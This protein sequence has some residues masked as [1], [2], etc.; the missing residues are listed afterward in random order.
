MVIEQSLMKSMK[1]EGGVSRGRSTQESVLSK[2]VYGMYVMNTIC[3]DVEKFCNISLDT[4]DQHV[5]TKDSRIKKDNDGVNKIIEWLTIH[6]PFSQTN[7]I[8]SL[9]NSIIGNDEINCYDAYEIGKH[10]MNKMVGLKFDHFKFKRA[11]RVL[12][13]LSVK[14]SIKVHDHSV[15][16]LLFQRIG[17]NTRFQHNLD[18]YLK[19]E[20]SPYPLAIFDDVGM[21]KTNKSILFKCF[22]PSVYEM[23]IS[24]ATYIIDGGFL[25]HRVIWHQDDTFQC[26]FNKYI[27]Y[28]KKYFRSNV[29]V[30]FDRYNDNSK[31]IKAM[32]QFRWSEAFS[33]SFEVFLIKQ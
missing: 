14:S 17:L 20:L 28:L 8:M 11:N 29:I 5:Y 25:L 16:L 3:E 31:T 1:S 24:N 23:D 4:V 12:P 26:I 19:Y 15:P 21:R 10:L 2:W 6:N 13:L 18:E 30:V 7:K 33:G 22:K 27:A 9:A 32:E